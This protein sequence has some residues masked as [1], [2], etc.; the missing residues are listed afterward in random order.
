[1]EVVKLRMILKNHSLRITDCRIEVL[2]FFSEK[3]YAIT[4]RDLEEKFPQYDRVTLFR[5]LN[6]FLKKSIIHRIPSDGGASSYA[7]N[8]HDHLAGS[9]EHDHIHFTCDSCGVIE[10]IELSEVPTI[11]L[12]GYLIKEFNYLIRGTCKNCISQ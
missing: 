10:C 12:P 9:H 5:T 1:M 11:E 2:N 4:S 6:S 7:L 3:D 8:I